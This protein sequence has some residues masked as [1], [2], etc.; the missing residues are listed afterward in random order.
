M[1]FIHDLQQGQRVVLAALFAAHLLAL[2]DRH[3]FGVTVVEVGRVLRV[4][5]GDVSVDV[6]VVEALDPVRIAALDSDLQM[7]DIVEPQAKDPRA[8][9]VGGHDV[10]AA[11]EKLQ[12]QDRFVR[13]R[14]DR[15][16]AV[17]GA[18]DAF[19]QA[20]VRTDVAEDVDEFAREGIV[21]VV[22]AVVL[23]RERP[24]VLDAH[25]DAGH[26]VGLQL[27]NGDVQVLVFILDEV[28]HDEL[29]HGQFRAHVVVPALELELHVL[30]LVEVDRNGAGALAHFVIAGDGIDETGRVALRRVLEQVDFL[31]AVFIPVVDGRF[32]HFRTGEAVRLPV[33]A[34]RLDEYFFAGLQHRRAAGGVKDLIDDF[35]RLFRQR[36][37]QRLELRQALGLVRG[38][39]MPHVHSRFSHNMILHLCYRAAANALT[40][41]VS[42]AALE[43]GSNSTQ[44]TRSNASGCAFTYSMTVSTAMSAAAASGY[45]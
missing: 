25:R 26:G 36:F 29:R 43:I 20:E 24:L 28:L 16:M 22:S 40:S 5:H 14:R 10:L 41:A 35:R 8:D 2:D 45:E 15:V 34:V 9:H 23:L 30:V 33:D 37:V 39:Q 11:D 17:D 31:R 12:R 38:L 3:V 27:R 1:V 4:V 42:Y 32:Q 6:D 19:E 13:Q 18:F 44:H 21:V 7:L